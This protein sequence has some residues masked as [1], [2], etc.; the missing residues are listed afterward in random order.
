[1]IDTIPRY[2][3]SLAEV[4]AAHGH[5]RSVAISREI[6]ADLDTPVSAYLKIREG[7]A[8]FLLESIEGGERVGRFSF[9]G[10]ARDVSRLKDG[11][12]ID[13]NG[14]TACDDP[15]E[16]IRTI[17]GRYGPSGTAGARFEG[18]ALGY[19][20][21]ESARYFERLPLPAH[22][23]LDLPDAAFM[24]VDTVLIFDHV[25][26]SIRIVSHAWLDRDPDV[27]YREAAGRI[28]ALVARLSRRPGPAASSLPLIG[29]LS[30]NVG[31]E[32]YTEMVRRGKEYIERGDIL[33]V[34]LS[35]RL[36]VPVDG[37]PFAL[38]RRLR[39]VSPSPYMYFLDFGDHQI[40]GASPEL[41]LQVEGETVTARPIAGTRRRGRNAAEDEALADEL[42]ADEKE[43]AEHLMLVDLARNDVGRV[44]QPGTVAVDHFMMVE[45][46]SHVMHLVSDVAGKL[47]PDL[48]AL[49]AL[50][51]AF[52]A[53]TVSGAPKIRAMEIIAELEPDRRGP[54]AG[55]VGFVNAGGDMEMAITIRT[56]VI[57]D[58]ALY[59]QAGAGI[60]A[61]SVPEGEY[62]ETMNKARAMLE[63]AGASDDFA[64]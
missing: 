27:A 23:P 45:R 51:A 19:L 40:V 46:F 38:Y 36:S 8:S 35:Q 10:V 39:G 34:V 58:G 32:R 50:R 3:P 47:R 57:K 48:T 24:D 49:D 6:M 55:A 16:L 1:M 25:R 7:G 15:L 33:Q 43:R 28:E 13:A 42:V 41:L 29:E 63:A 59:V 22:D 60:V 20:A 26:H 64:D 14:T 18:G 4:Q 52:P 56:A 62:V 12:L 44:S 11:S 5:A 21:Y 2:A 31:H 17:V 61:D 54:Y 30:S 53:G 37:D 9:I